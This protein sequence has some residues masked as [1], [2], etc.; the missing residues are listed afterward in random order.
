MFKILFPTF[1]ISLMAFCL[2]SCNEESPVGNE[3]LTMENGYQ[4]IHHIQ[5]EGP[6]PQ[7]GEVAWYYFSYSADDSLMMDGRD[8]GMVSRTQI[9]EAL[10]DGRRISS[11]TVDAIRLMSI[12]DSVTVIVPADSIPELPPG[13]ENVENF[14]YDLVLIDIKTKEENARIVEA[15]QK[16]NSIRTAEIDS[17]AKA[18]IEDHKSGKLA[19]EIVEKPSGLKYFII[20]AGSGAVPQE[21][22]VIQMRY[23]AMFSNGETFDSTFPGGNSF[24]I[25]VGA[26]TVTPGLDEALTYLNRGTKALVFVPYALGYGEEGIPSFIPPKSDLAYYVEVVR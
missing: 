15:E 4:Y 16:Q 7:V 17:L 13:F 8:A 18:V 9:A 1:F 23:H 3:L 11:P 10:R 2:M 5:N 24:P 25:K 6:K 21:G 14:Y 22:E 19:D 26:G 20:E 12:G